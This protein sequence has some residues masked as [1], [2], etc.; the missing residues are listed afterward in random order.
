MLV[1]ILSTV[2]PMALRYRY[3]FLRSKAATGW[4]CAGLGEAQEGEERG[5]P[6]D[7]ALFFFLFGH[8][9]GMQKFHTRDHTWARTVI[10][11]TTVT[12]LDP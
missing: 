12:M 11:A 8:A 9:C 6:F 10:Q 3:K 5:V 1:R 4:T 2:V 7:R